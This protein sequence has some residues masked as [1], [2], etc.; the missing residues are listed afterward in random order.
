MTRMTAFSSPFLL[1]FDQIETM[2]DRI[3]KSA[4]DSYPPYNIERLAP[5]TGGERL[6][7]CLAV[8]G[9]RA[10]DLDITLE[11]SVLTIRGEQVDDE[12]RDFLHRGIAA[13]RFERCFVLADGMQVEGAEVENGL[14]AVDLSRPPPETTVRRIPVTNRG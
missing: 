11:N 12:T 9:F 4:G 8:A 3:S 7:I 2:L 1:G 10:E 5:G 6:R 14:L 13:R